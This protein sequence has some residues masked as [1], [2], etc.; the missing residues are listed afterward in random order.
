MF[1]LCLF[2]CV[3]VCVC[4]VC[5]VQDLCIRAMMCCVIPVSFPKVIM[6]TSWH[7]IPSWVYTFIYIHVHAHVYIYYTLSLAENSK[8][9]FDVITV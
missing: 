5:K 9:L 3:C 8:A 6:C 1:V 2:V 7:S 4:V